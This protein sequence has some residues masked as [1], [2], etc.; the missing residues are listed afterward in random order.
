[1]IVVVKRNLVYSLIIVKL[2]TCFDSVGLLSGLH[3]EPINIIKLRTSLRSQQCWD[4]K[5]VRSF[6]TL[7]GS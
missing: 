4:P 2:A 5:D 1:M 3:Y 6:L 7:T